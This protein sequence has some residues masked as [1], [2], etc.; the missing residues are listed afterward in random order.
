MFKSNHR[1][2]DGLSFLLI[3]V[4]AVFVVL[5]NVDALRTDIPAALEAAKAA[6]PSVQIATSPV[7]ESAPL[8]H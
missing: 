1:L 4:M 6:D 8:P 5:A 7:P 2:D 3:A